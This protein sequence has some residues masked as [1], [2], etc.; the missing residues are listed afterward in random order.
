MIDDTERPDQRVVLVFGHGHSLTALTV[1]WLGL[2]LGEGRHLRLGTGGLSVLGWKRGLRI[3]EEWN[4]R[5]H[6]PGAT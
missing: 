3:L 6:V 4:D 1:R 5:S 2:P